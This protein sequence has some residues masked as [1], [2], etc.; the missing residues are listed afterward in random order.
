MKISFSNFPQDMSEEDINKVFSEYGSIDKLILK[1][2]KL[3]KKSL[4]FGS[5]EMDDSSAEKAI[6][7]LEGK[8]IGE[9]KISVGDFEALQA[10][11]QTGKNAGGGLSNSSGKSFGKTVMGGGGVGIQRRG[12]NRGS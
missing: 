11:L 9:R 5:L 3:T 12:G 1:R 6:S 8:E 10:K 7:A 2:D 4:G